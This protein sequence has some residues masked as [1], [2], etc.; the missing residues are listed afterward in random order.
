MAGLMQLV[1][2]LL[3]IQP[4]GFTLSQNNTTQTPISISITVPHDVNNATLCAGIN[5]MK[6][7]A[8]FPHSFTDWVCWNVNLRELPDIGETFNHTFAPR[9]TG[10]YYAGAVLYVKI[11]KPVVLPLQE[12]EVGAK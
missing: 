4:F 9:S 5:D 11:G 2:L 3:V 12:F 10:T 1:Y 8:D 6:S 7:Y